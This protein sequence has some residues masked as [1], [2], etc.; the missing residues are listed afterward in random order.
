M[1]AMLRAL[2]AV[3]DIVSELRVFLSLYVYVRL[4]STYSGKG[5]T[6]Q[7]SYCI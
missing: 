2:R 7:E 4:C 6:Y 3:Y 1:Y 5:V